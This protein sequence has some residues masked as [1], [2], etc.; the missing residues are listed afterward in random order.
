DRHVADLGVIRKVERAVVGAVEMD[1]VT[2]AGDADLDAVHVEVDVGGKLEVVA[3]RLFGAERYGGGRDG[4]LDAA[5][6]RRQMHFP[7]L[8][9]TAE[10][11]AIVSGHASFGRRARADPGT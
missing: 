10:V 6:G 11:A 7:R 3:R 1:V 8:P 9:A 5:R 2:A 4:E